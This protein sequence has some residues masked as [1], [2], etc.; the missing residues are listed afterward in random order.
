[1][2]ARLVRLYHNPRLG[3]I[4]RRGV[5]LDAAGCVI[6]YRIVKDRHAAAALEIPEHVDVNGWSVS[7]KARNW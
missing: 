3:T 1:M 5:L 6:P 7:V 2:R 4:D